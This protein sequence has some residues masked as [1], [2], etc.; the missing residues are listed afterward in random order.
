MDARTYTAMIADIVDSR[1]PI[2]MDTNDRHVAFYTRDGAAYCPA[3]AE[4]RFNTMAC[5]V[6]V[7]FVHDESVDEMYCDDCAYED[8][9]SKYRERG[10][11]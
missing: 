8:V 4:A 2:S 5:D 1:E 11:I 3:H 10:R 9:V 7:V 6:G